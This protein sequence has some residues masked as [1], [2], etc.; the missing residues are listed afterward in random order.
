MLHQDPEQM[1]IFITGIGG[2]GKSHVIRA[3]LGAFVRTS[4]Y[5]QILLS[6]P[7]GSAACLIDGYTI[8]TLTLMGVGSRSTGREAF[9]DGLDGK[10]VKQKFNV[11]ELQEIW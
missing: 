10:I 2:S 3:I 9:E 4:R 5:Q 1:L 6:A 7:T 11:D 8:H